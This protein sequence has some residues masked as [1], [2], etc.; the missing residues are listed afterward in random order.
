MMLQQE[1]PDDYVIATGISH[2]VKDYLDATFQLAGLNIHNHVI[3]SERLFRPQEVNVLIG[4]ASK[5]K[6][7]LGWKPKMTFEQLVETMYKF[8]YD[9]EKLLHGIV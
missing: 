3:I 5:A 9:N 8:D 4:D 1:K 6:K 7:V 2:T